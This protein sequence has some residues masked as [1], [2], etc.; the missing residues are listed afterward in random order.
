MDRDRSGDGGEGGGD[1]GGMPSGPMILRGASSQEYWFEEGCHITE[2]LN[3]PD[4]PGLSVARA[5]VTPGV[6]TRLHRLAGIAERYVVLE[7]EGRVEL[8]G[9]DSA[10]TS[11][12]VS[13]SAMAAIAGSSGSPNR[14][15]SSMCTTRCTGYCTR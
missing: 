2:W 3:S 15:R 9:P 13:D 5:R 1:G 11:A 12:S 6:T 8:V 4:D 7:G 14:L 10:M